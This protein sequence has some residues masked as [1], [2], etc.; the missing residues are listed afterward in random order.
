ML[1]CYIQI[2]TTV[3]RVNLKEKRK[4]QEKKAESPTPFMKSL[5]GADPHPLV[6]SH[7]Q[8]K[9]FPNLIFGPQCQ[10]KS[11][12]VIKSL[13]L[14]GTITMLVAWV[15]HMFCYLSSSSVTTTTKN[16][17]K[18]TSSMI[19]ER[20]LNKDSMSMIPER[21]HVTTKKLQTNC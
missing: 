6:P 21:F 5:L 15:K 13:L 14:V 1:R 8:K 9:K 3:N 12:N 17:K 20:I 4:K 7:P 2:W 19:P 18:S 16:R 10:A 11:R